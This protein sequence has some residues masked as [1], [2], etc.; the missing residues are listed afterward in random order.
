MNVGQTLVMSR[1]HVPWWRT[2]LPEPDDVRAS[3]WGPRPDPPDALLRETAAD[4]TVIL[5]QYQLCVEMA[6]R[7]SARRSLTNTFF[8]TLNTA[9]FTVVGVFWKDRPD[10]AAGLV[11][12]PA[13]ILVVQCGAWFA[14]LRSYRQLS[15]AK[16]VVIG[17]LEERLPASPYWR[18]EWSALGRGQEPSRYWPLTHVEQVVPAL[19]AVAYAGSAVL[20][21]TLT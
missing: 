17:V 10:A 5:Q 2:S 14:L 9:V 7:V 18:G 19:F 1:Q 11:T 3:L 8:L 6:D 15:A 21:I 4:R 16:Y 20:A 12:L 13:L